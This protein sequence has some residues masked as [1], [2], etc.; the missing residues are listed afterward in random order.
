MK[1]ITR[2]FL[3]V[4]SFLGVLLFFFIKSDIDIPFVNRWGWCSPEIALC[5][6]AVIA[7]IGATVFAKLILKSSVK[8][9]GN[10][11]TI[12]IKQIKPME[13]NYLPIYIG[14]FV[15]ALDLGDTITMQSIILLILLFILWLFLENTSYFNPFFLCWGYK[16]YEVVT[17]TKGSMKEGTY[18][19]ITKHKDLKSIDS[20]DQLTRLNNFTFLQY[21]K[22]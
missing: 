17:E 6:K 19:L 18:T 7:I 5:L 1:S 10:E 22:P 4:S 15:V 13:G 20:L 21:K 8:Y 3:S 2:F 11:D 9:L 12:K 16:F 14:L